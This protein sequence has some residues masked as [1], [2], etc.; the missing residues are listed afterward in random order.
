MGGF[1]SII[2]M[3]EE[4]VHWIP[5]RLN[6]LTIIHMQ[7]LAVLDR[8]LVTRAEILEGDILGL[9]TLR[10]IQESVLPQRPRWS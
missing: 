9:Q 3:E 8:F 1:D 7:A 4:T 5:L 2:V 10:D 6:N